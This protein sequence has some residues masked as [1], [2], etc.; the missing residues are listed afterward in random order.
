MLRAGVPE[1][2]IY[3][4]GQLLLRECDVDA[5]AKLGQS[6]IVHPVA[7]SEGV[8]RSAQGKLGTGVAPSIGLHDSAANR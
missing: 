5:S 7:V 6:P 4:N 1:A 2:A 8:E 3:E